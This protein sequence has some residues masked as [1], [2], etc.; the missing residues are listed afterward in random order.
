MTTETAEPTTAEWIARAAAVQPRTELFIDGRF[1]PAASGRTFDDIAGRDGTV[2][3]RVAEGDAEDVDR[4]VA[5]ARGSFDD[6]RW[7]DQ[8][9]AARKRVLLR[10]AELVREHLDELALL[11][12]LDVGKPI[13]DTLS[14]D[15]PSAATT[16]QWYAET[17]DKAYGEVGPTGPGRPVARDSRADRRGR[18]DR[19]VELPDD[20]HRLEARRSARDRQFGGAQAGQPVASHCPAPR[21]AGGGSRPPRR[22]PQRRHRVRARSSATPW[23]ATRASTRSRSPARPRSGCR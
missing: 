15:I 16:L 18:R 17:I 22:R 11:E 8:P 7:S 10:L 9:P 1:G 23:L 14:V 2:I 5:A 4:A 6:R 20:H 13:R 12:S 21:R 3:A 19:P